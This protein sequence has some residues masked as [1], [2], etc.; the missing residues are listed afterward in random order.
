MLRLQPAP[1]PAPTLLQGVLEGLTDG[2]LIL[3]EQGNWV[4]GNYY[5]HCICQ[6]LNPSPLSAHTVPDSIWQ[7]CEALI[8][9][10]DLYPTQPIIL[11]SELVLTRAQ[12]FRIRVR[13]LPLQD[14]QHP[15][16]LVL[17]ED[18]YQSTQHRA[19]AD[20]QQYGLTPRQA[21]VW[22]LYCMGNSCREIASE[23]YISVNTVKKHLKD[24]HLKR[25]QASNKD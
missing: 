10:R 20:V 23:L 15:Y 11:E 8:D 9:S 19:I 14:A 2:V 6:Q 24:I 1:H 17:I 18:R 7:I 4:Y 12:K 5:A 25:Q 22:L 21:E 3:T 16:L 13:W